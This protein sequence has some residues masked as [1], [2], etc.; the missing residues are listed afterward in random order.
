MTKN[1][2]ITWFL[3]HFLWTSEV[4]ALGGNVYTPF[5]EGLHFPNNSQAYNEHQNYFN[6]NENVTQASETD[7]W[8]WPH[9]WNMF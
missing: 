7:K 8:F 1:L 9:I 4:L 2:R 3:E 6:K 5:Q